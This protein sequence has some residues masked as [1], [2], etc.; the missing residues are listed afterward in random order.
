MDGL[1]ITFLYLYLL[2]GAAGF[3]QINGGGQTSPPL[4]PESKLEFEPPQRTPLGSM[5]TVMT[6][7]YSCAD[8]GSVFLLITDSP[9]TMQLTLHSLKS[10][11]E[12]VRYVAPRIPGYEATGWPQ[13]YFVD[14]RQVAELWETT[15]ARNPLERQEGPP[16]SVWLV[17]LYDRTGKFENAI[18]LPSEIAPK[19]VGVYGSGNLLVIASDKTTKAAGMYVLSPRGDIIRQFLLFDEDY[20]TGRQSKSK[21]PLETISPDGA[22][23]FV[24]IVSSGSNLLL[25]PRTT[26]ESVIEVNEHGVVRTVELKLPKGTSI[27]SF[28]SRNGYRWKVLTYSTAK[29]TT[30]D[31]NG[32]K[33]GELKQGAVLEFN[34]FDGTLLRRIDL[35]EKRNALLACEHSGDYSALT[36]DP[37]DGRLEIVKGAEVNQ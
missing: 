7:D 34:S 20:N 19:A 27:G 32:E 16:A 3:S 5:G 17:L 26:N 10:P 35:P 18:P 25:F 13:S 11:S 29:I 9:R 22:L 6:A 24:K 36:T 14:D 37:K 30:D 12:D 23:T 4:V 8:D 1:R 2:T 28:L 21:Q 15:I 31:K 33:S